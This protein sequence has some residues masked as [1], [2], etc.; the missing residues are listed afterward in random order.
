MSLQKMIAVRAIRRQNR[1]RSKLKRCS[2]GKLRISI[3]RTLQ[4]ISVQLI[5]DSAHR[6]VLSASS[7]Q[8]PEKQ[9]GTKRDIAKIV[10]LT[11]GKGVLA[12]GLANVYIDRGSYLYHGRVSALVEGIRDSGLKV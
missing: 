4:H 6:T 3:H 2:Q 7:Q 10:G 1:T 8:L 12:Q 11:F 5:D 9:Q